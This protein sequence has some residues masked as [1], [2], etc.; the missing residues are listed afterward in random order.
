MLTI[1][2]Q[3]IVAGRPINVHLVL[4]YAAFF[5]A[6][7][8]YVYLRKRSSDPISSSNRLSIILGAAAGAFVGSR[9]VAFLENPP[10]DITF[11]VILQ[12]YTVKTIMGGLFGGMLGV[13]I[14]KWKLNIKQSSG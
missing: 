11:H 12:L 9:V 5:I 3:P 13:E 7:R 1:P 14:V 4:E 10:D 2:Y 8:Y 6:F